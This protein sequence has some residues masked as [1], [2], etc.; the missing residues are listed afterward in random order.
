[1]FLM[2]ANIA[3]RNVKILE[4]IVDLI[5]L[6][7]L[8]SRPRGRAREDLFLSPSN[9]LILSLLFYRQDKV[10]TKA[11]RLVDLTCYVG[12]LNVLCLPF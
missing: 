11:V 3:N 2:R 6:E 8:Y 12:Q 7:P 9:L 5:T 10:K 1:M 4:N